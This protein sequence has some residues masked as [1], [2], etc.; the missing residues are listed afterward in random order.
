[1]AF[2]P[3]DNGLFPMKDNILLNRNT[4]TSIS[5]ALKIQLCSYIQRNCCLLMNAILTS[6]FNYTCTMSVDLAALGDMTNTVTKCSFRFNSQHLS[7]EIFNMK[8]DNQSQ[9]MCSCF[10]TL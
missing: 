10:Y 5:N 3:F 1:M 8:V 9:D 6:V 4:S 7:Y 2:S